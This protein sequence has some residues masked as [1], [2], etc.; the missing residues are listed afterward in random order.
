MKL[1]RIYKLIHGLNSVSSEDRGFP[2]TL[3]VILIVKS[4]QDA[5]LSNIPFQNIGVT[6]QKL[7]ILSLTDL[8]DDLFL[9]L[10]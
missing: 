3:E 7:L 6:E 8:I 5:L 4:R 1:R 10:H 2:F 9:P